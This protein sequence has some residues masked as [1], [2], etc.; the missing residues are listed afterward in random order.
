MQWVNV[1]LENLLYTWNLQLFDKITS[2][3]TTS[4]QSCTVLVYLKPS[5]YC[6]S[7]TNL[8]T[9]YSLKLPN[10]TFN[11]STETKGNI[12][13]RL[14]PKAANRFNTPE[15]NFSQQYFIFFIKSS[16][17]CSPSK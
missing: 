17:F 9:N 12:S 3:F 2:V 1:F 5:D 7:L 10:L 13:C 16:D 8:F 4:G 6:D 14:P 11:H 15:N